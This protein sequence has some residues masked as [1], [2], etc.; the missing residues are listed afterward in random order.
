MRPGNTVEVELD[1]RRTARMTLY[2]IERLRRATIRDDRP[3]GIDLA[4]GTSMPGEW[5]TSDWIAAF[6]A[7]LVRDD[8]DLTED[9]LAM[10]VDGE[11]FIALQRAFFKLLGDF[12]PEREDAVDEEDAV[13]PPTPA[14]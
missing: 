14:T 2:E 11:A 8:P 6:W 10:L 3:R 5:M 9:D 12:F 4:S 13:D 7:I 1:R